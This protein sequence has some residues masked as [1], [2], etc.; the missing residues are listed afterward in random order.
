MRHFNEIHEK[1]IILKK[2]KK[3]VIKFAKV[4]DAPLYA[5]S[6]QLK[7]LNDQIDLLKWV[8]KIK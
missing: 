7:S 8:L 6:K 5:I 4:N 3:D 1:M 2:I